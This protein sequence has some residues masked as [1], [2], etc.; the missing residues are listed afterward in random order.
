MAD[1]ENRLYYGDNLDVLRDHSYFPDRSVDLVYLDP[2]FNSNRDYNAFFEQ[3]DGRRAA[4]QIKAFTDTW[5]WDVAAAASYQSV[6]EQG[7]SAADVLVGLQAILGNNDVLA[8]L[9]MMAPRLI[10]MRRVMNE[11]ASIFLHCD[12]T[13]SHYLKV[14]M[15]GVF[16]ADCFVNEIIWHYR[17]WAAGRFAFQRNHDVI[18]YY[19]R[20]PGR[21][22]KFNQLFMDR[23]D[24]TK[25]RFGTAKI[26]SGYD[27]EGR[28]LPSVTVEGEESEGVR[29]DDVWD[30]GRVPPIKQLFPTQKPLPLLERIIAAT[31]DEGD[32]V[33]DPFCGC[34]TAIVAAQSMKR[35]WRG[36][37][38][39]HL[40][41]NL[42][43]TRLLDIFGDVEYDVIGEPT[44]LD[45][46]VQLAKED[47]YQFQWWSLGL[48]GARPQEKK[49]GADTGIDGKLFF[50]DDSR[51]GTK[52][53]IF[54]VKSGKLKAT[55]VRDLRGVI[56]R[57]GAQIGVLV[58]MQAPTNGMRAEAASAG[59][60]KSHWGNHSRLQVLTIEDILNGRRVDSPP[61]GL[62]N[63]TF[64]RAS[65]ET[66]DRADDTQTELQFPE[67]N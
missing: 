49:K 19:T 2:P 35:K 17:K 60:Y 1:G 57:E 8:Y 54:S 34:G 41:T 62:V 11:T 66:P 3:Q 51:G 7:G 38:I 43:K 37:D 58:T 24:S 16:G 45:G 5:K 6:V 63:V 64:K 46:A 59:F 55:D 33:L 61:L 21:V 40:A 67:S 50:H 65:A 31:T 27:E 44:T 30:I 28:R 48:L 26:V 47:P 22:A 36:I 9:S 10:E 13:A 56:E 42:I 20:R 39:T 52:Q 12:P 4:A 32:V 23:A 18:L 14:L 15:D 53:M 29:M 25:K